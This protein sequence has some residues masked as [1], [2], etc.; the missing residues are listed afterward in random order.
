MDAGPHPRGPVNPMKKTT[1]LLLLGLLAAGALLALAGAAEVCHTK[2][3]Q[4]P[5][6]LVGVHTAVHIYDAFWG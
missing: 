4:T 6:H 3:V 2:D 5:D 1:H